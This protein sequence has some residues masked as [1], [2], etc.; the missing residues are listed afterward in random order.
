MRRSPRPMRRMRPWDRTSL[1]LALALWLVIAAP[2]RAQDDNAS[3]VFDDE[4]PAK[5]SG[6]EK[7]K[8]KDTTKK[9][10]DAKPS[11]PVDKNR[12]APGT[13]ADRDAIGFTQA[14]AA[15]QM[16]E[17]E[18]RMFRLSEALRGLEPEN[19]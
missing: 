15:S 11:A 4:N 16:T 6:T 5:S 7:P 17:L 18:E 12:P 2:S 13:A 9:D 10:T 3:G 1:I 19:A 14:N 8:A